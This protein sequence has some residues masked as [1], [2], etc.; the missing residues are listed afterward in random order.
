M[1][2]LIVFEYLKKHLSVPVKAERDD[3]L[4]RYVYMEKT[5][6]NGKFIHSCTMAIQ[7]Y[8]GDFLNTVKLNEEVKKVMSGLIEMDEITKCEL[9]NDYVF[10]DLVRKKNRYQAIFEIAYY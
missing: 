1:I 5:Q 7:S 10:N 8:G 3:N 4:D 6:N 9:V 2:E